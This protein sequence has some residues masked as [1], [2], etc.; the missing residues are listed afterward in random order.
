MMLAGAE[1]IRVVAEV[2]DG[3]EVARAVDA[4]RAPTSC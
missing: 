2:A 1:D 3:S 4:L